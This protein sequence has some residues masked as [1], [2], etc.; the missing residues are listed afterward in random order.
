MKN[1]FGIESDGPLIAR[2]EPFIYGFEQR[3]TNSY[4]NNGHIALLWYL[5]KLKRLIFTTF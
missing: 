5:F 1:Q 2:I 4:K 3:A